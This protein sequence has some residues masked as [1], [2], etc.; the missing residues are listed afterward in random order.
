MT[1]ENDEHF[2][3]RPGPPLTEEQIVAS[4]WAADAIRTRLQNLR[5]TAQHWQSSISTI[6]ALFGAA[7]VLNADNAVRAIAPEWSYLYGLLVVLSL[8]CAALALQLAS[9]A[10][11]P[12]RVTVPAALDKQVNLYNQVFDTAKH[13]LSL[14]R[15]FAAL[16][17]ALLI[18]TIG[19]RWYAPHN[20][21][22][23]SR[24]SAVIAIR[25]SI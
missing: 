20:P 13:R 17:V 21:E 14:S 3:I 18:L 8:V 25:P 15:L 10:G 6:T 12:S 11:E 19:V 24:S 1:A 9:Q 4:D 22:A 5:T 16:A 2:T 7:T 23:A